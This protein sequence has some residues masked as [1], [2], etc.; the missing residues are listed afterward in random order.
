MKKIII[1]TLVALTLSLAATSIALALPSNSGINKAGEKSPAIEAGELVAPPEFTVDLPENQLTKVVFIRYAPGLE[2]LCNNNGIC[3]PKENWKSCSSDCTKG[4]D[5]GGDTATACYG[6]LSGAKPHW[7]W[8]EN[9]YYNDVGLGSTSAWATNVWNQATGATIFGNAVSGAASWGVYDQKNSIV[10]GNYSEAGVIGVTAIWFQG[11]NIYEYDILFDTDYFPGLGDIDLDTVVLHEF[12]HGAGLD[13]L[14][15]SV[16]ATEVM[17]GYYDGVDL[18]LGPG[19]LT[20]I[21][22]LYGN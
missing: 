16:C 22:T 13:D 19:D 1:I 4:G 7:Q 2:P 10:Y 21:H 14:Y 15:N 11:K 3:E 6:F 9:Y 5:S 8:V 17:Y 18:D 12:G 20:G